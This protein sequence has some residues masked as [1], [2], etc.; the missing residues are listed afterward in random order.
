MESVFTVLHVVMSIINFFRVNGTV[1]SLQGEPVYPQIWKDGDI[2]V[3]GAFPFY[4]SWE[5][6]DLSYVVMPPPMK[7]IR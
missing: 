1:C 6:I 2:V 7:C 5:T 4:S 3:G